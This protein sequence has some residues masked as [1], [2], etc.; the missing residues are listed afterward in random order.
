MPYLKQ[1]MQPADGNLLLSKPMYEG[2]SNQEEILI[3]N[4]RSS[5]QAP[6]MY[7]CVAVNT[8]QETARL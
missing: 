3:Q 2:R 5:H 4:A 7:A 6:V 8:R 1:L